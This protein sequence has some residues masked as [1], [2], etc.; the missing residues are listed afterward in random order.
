VC[1]AL[2]TGDLLLG[3]AGGAAL[4]WQART[5]ALVS[6]PAYPWP[7]LSV[8]TDAAGE[9]LLV[10]RGNGMDTTHLTSY[11][12]HEAAYRAG[13]WRLVNAQGEGRLASLATVQGK[14]GFGL[15]DGA[16]LTLLT[17]RDYLPYQRIEPLP[18]SA[19]EFRGA[20]AVWPDLLTW[21]GVL[22]P[23]G[24]WYNALL[25]STYC[26]R[27][28]DIGWQA[29]MPA[30]CGLEHPP[31]SWLHLPGGRLEMAGVSPSGSLCWSALLVPEGARTAY[32]QAGNG[33]GFRAGCLIGPGE[34]A[35]VTAGHVRW[36]RCGPAYFTLRA[37][38]KSDLGDAVA[39][40]PGPLGSELLVVCA[41]GDV[42]RVPVPR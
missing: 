14:N 1:A 17:E 2:R 27:R 41:G 34:V 31:L 37:T 13:P 3:F 26:W 12:I 38:T 39:C 32:I 33:D 42:V 40:F 4:C 19:E 10:L 24:L 29:G 20:L 11:T 7:V 18:I 23:G 16:T 35:G 30:G 25:S 21:P 8:A 22:D 6:L 36:M 28:I 15:W 5:G 9:H